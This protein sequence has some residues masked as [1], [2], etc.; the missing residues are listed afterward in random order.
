MGCKLSVNVVHPLRSPKYN[1]KSPAKKPV[2]N[3]PP[4]PSRACA[5]ANDGKA[6][7]RLSKTWFMK[8]LGSNRINDCQAQSILA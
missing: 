6:R 3:P 7:E 1:A 2:K 8:I 5:N 4:A